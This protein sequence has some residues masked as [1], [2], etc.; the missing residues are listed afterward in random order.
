[1]QVISTLFALA[2]APTRP[3]RAMV[4]CG[5]KMPLWMS[6]RSGYLRGA[7]CWPGDDLVD[8]PGDVAFEA[9]D[10]LAAGFPF[11]DAGSR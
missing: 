8:L 1:M 7:W 3:P 6:S 2:R 4:R 5:L 10:R 11:A 9:A